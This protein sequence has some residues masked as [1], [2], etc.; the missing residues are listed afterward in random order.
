MEF[1]KIKNG[2]EGEYNDERNQELILRYKELSDREKNELF[3]LNTGLVYRIAY[4]L[5]LKNSYTDSE[6]FED[7]LAVGFVG[8]QKALEH[9]EPEYN[10]KF[11]TFAG[12]C[13]SNE[14]LMYLR[15]NNHRVENEI[16]MDIKIKHVKDDKIS[17]EDLLPSSDKSPKEM[18][19]EL[20]EQERFYEA[21]HSLS[22]DEQNFLVK[23]Y[24][25]GETERLTQIQLSEELHLSQSYIS[26][27][28]KKLEKKL[29]K[30]YHYKR[31]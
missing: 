3:Q 24:G 16:S 15:K 8:L 28:R 4:Q 27:K 29:Q 2:V 26:R 12:R 20:E 18:I 13:I 1:L 30:L 21:F 19:I 9:F 14:I 17:I 6:F 23:C 11:S 7:L 25:L 5:Y 31:K 10:I 22:I